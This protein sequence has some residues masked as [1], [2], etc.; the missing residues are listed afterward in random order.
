MV[1]FLF[2]TDSHATIA[3]DTQVVVAE[4]KG[5][6]IRRVQLARLRTLEAAGTRVVAIGEFAK[7]LGGVAAQRIN[8]DLAIFGDHHFE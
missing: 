5:I 8:L 2:G 3:G 6:V 1:A 4:D 7:L